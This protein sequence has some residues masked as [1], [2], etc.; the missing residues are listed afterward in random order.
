M[1]WLWEQ[2]NIWRRERKSPSLVSFHPHPCPSELYLPAKSANQRTRRIFSGRVSPPSTRLSEGSTTKNLPKQYNYLTGLCIS[3]LGNPLLNLHP[4]SRTISPI[5][6]TKLNKPN[7]LQKLRSGGDKQPIMKRGVRGRR[8]QA[9]NY[10]L[11]ITGR[12][13][14]DAWPSCTKH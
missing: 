8:V 11:Q 13:V 2:R 5:S 14:F 7:W 1:L 6:L 10:R 4:N 9:C 3:T 12:I